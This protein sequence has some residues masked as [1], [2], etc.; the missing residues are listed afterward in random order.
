[1]EP[2]GARASRWQGPGDCV[3]SGFLVG[4]TRQG[5]PPDL[6]AGHGPHRHHQGPRSC[7]L[8]CPRESQ[9]WGSWA[10]TILGAQGGWGR[11]RAHR[12]ARWFRPWGPPRWPSDRTFAMCMVPDTECPRSGTVPAFV[13]LSQ[14]IHSPCLCLSK[15]LFADQQPVGV[16]HTNPETVSGCSLRPRVNAFPA[17]G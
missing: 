10:I 7:S 8:S 3:L 1:M 15:P 4:G 6:Q 12:A 5:C 9:S 16:Q 17:A 2:R 14:I 13:C 11:H